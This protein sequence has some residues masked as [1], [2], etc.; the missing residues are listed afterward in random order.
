MLTISQLADYAGTTVRAVRHYHA[1]G[2]LP[3]PERDASGYRTY[4]AQAIVDLRRIRML[5]DAGVPLKRIAALVR[6]SPEVLRDAVAAIDRDLR[7]RIRELQA[8]RRHL[9]RLASEDE[10]FLPEGV[11]E[12][13]DE[14][15]AMG[16]AER[17][18][19]MDREGWILT[20]ALYPQL[21]EAWIGIQR[22]MLA[23][24]EYRTL[25]LLTDQCFDWNPDDP[26]I[27]DLARRTVAFIRSLPLP[28]S[29]SWDADA[30]AYQ[31]VTT[32][33]RDESPAWSR[34]MDRVGELLA[35][36]PGPQPPGATP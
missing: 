16:V 31:L 14:M 19:A 29:S 12:L 18:L 27:E 4:G 6:A 32:Y 34:L 28:D 5:A 20:G 3:E 8:T 23:N 9:A 10:P 13:H 36:Q 30:T 15:R 25:T 26:R 22:S 21:T 35:D 7:A 33:R 1:V 11:K 17:T 2:L 24:P